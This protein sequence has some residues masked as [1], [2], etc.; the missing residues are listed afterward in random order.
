MIAT[1]KQFKN[2]IMLITG[3]FFVLMLFLNTHIIPTGC[4]GVLVRFG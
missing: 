3:I 4:T 2:L 1:I